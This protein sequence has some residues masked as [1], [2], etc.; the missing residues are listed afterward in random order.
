MHA[1]ALADLIEQHLPAAKAGDR[2]AF[3]RIVVGCQNGITAIALAITRDV[4]TS[5][6]IAQDA[7]LNAWNNLSRLRNPRSFLPWLRQITR[8]LSHDA[9]RRRKAERRVDGDLD[10]ILA[11]VAD[12]TPDHPERLARHQEESVVA[13]LIDE[14]PE[15]TREILLIYYREGQSSK[16]VAHLLGMQ[17]AAVRKRLS[18]ARQSLRD[19]L[20]ARLGELAR[21]TAPTAAFTAIVVAGLTISQPAAAAGLAAAGASVA[22]GL[23]G[24]ASSA[25]AALGK[26]LGKSAFGTALVGKGASRLLIGAVGGIVFALIAGIAGVIFGVRRH[27]I[28]AIDE[29]E[30]RDL[31]WFAAAG[32]GTVFL[33]TGLMAVSLLHASAWLPTASF[34]GLMVAI[35]AMNLTWL[36]C[37]LARRHAREHDN[38]PIRA[39]RERVAERRM[40]WSGMLIGVLLGGSGLLVGL[41]TSGR[42]VV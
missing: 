32:I 30:K 4:A 28:T 8:N 16:Q 1:D 37:I 18:R 2:A 5:E 9:L 15:E 11:V 27:W 35:G 14:L 38:D 22:G 33:F 31:A 40:A 17:D 21:T 24:K 25:V 3:G 13:D 41:L 26:G 34:V 29:Q 39:A 7:F 36:P 20:L 19:D 10:D 23:V 6:D 42:M 12:P